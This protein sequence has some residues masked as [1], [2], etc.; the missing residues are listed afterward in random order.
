[1]PPRPRPHWLAAL[2]VLT[3]VASGCAGARYS[4]ADPGAERRAL[5]TVDITT[6]DDGKRASELADFARSHNDPEGAATWAAI[7]QR[8][9]L[10]GATVSDDAKAK[11]RWR[12]ASRR[13]RRLADRGFQHTQHIDAILLSPKPELHRA[14]LRAAVRHADLPADDAAELLE[15]ASR[16]AD[17]AAVLRAWTPWSTARKTHWLEAFDALPSRLRRDPAVLARALDCALD[18]E[19]PSAELAARAT[20]LLEYDPWHVPA[21]LAL[22]INIGNTD[23]DHALWPDIV[24]V[25]RSR[26]SSTVAR[27]QQRYGAE[28]TQARGLALA[29]VLLQSNM[30]G[31]ARVV[32]DGVPAS[33]D[34][35]GEAELVRALAALLA[36]EAAAYDRWRKEHDEP[37][38]WLDERIA[39]WDFQEHG[40]QTR[41]V[42]AAARRRAQRAG[43]PLV[44]TAIRNLL[45]AESSLTQRRRARR[46]LAVTP[47]IARVAE[48]CA[49]VGHSADRCLEVVWG[50]ASAE[51]EEEDLALRLRADAIADYEVADLDDE[52][53]ARLA[54]GAQVAKPGL[55]EALVLRAIEDRRLDDAARQLARDGVVLPARTLLRLELVLKDA[56]AGY[57]DVALGWLP[58]PFDVSSGD[59][60]L[61]VA[62][63]KKRPTARL[64]EALRRLQEEPAAALTALNELTTE[65]DGRSRILLLCYAAIAS[66]AA[67]D[68]GALDEISRSIA[69]D[70]PDSGAAAVVESLRARQRGNS[71]RAREAAGV[72]AVRAPQSRLALDNL[73]RES[74]EAASVEVEVFHGL[75]RAAPY[76]WELHYSALRAA[77]RDEALPTPADV[78]NARELLDQDDDVDTVAMARL[79]PQLADAAVR[80]EFARMHAAGEGSVARSAAAN[81]LTALDLTPESEGWESSRPALLM[82]ADRADEAVLR[83]DASKHGDGVD[84]FSTMAYV[85]R[86][87]ASGALSDT[88]AY[89]LWRWLYSP[90][91]DPPEVLTAIADAPWSPAL[92][93]IACVEA[94]TADAV[95]QARSHCRE[96]HRDFPLD[97]GVAVNLGWAASQDTEDLHIENAL[98]AD[99]P[100]TFLEDR[101]QPIDRGSWSIWFANKAKWQD[102]RGETEQAHQT[103]VDAIALGHPVPKGVSTTESDTLGVLLRHGHKRS[104]VVG[105]HWARVGYLAL[106]NGDVQTAHRYTSA[107][108]RAVTDEADKSIQLVVGQRHAVVEFAQRDLRS[109]AASPDEIGEALR[110]AGDGDEAQLAAFVQAHPDCTLGLAARATRQLDKG[111]AQLAKT[112][113]DALRKLGSHEAATEHLA[114]RLALLEGELPR[115]KAIYARAIRATPGHLMLTAATLPESLR[116][117]DPDVPWWVR[118][119]RSADAHVVPMP[120]AVARRINIASAEDFFAPESWTV[121]AKA[122]GSTTVSGPQGAVVEI[123]ERSRAARC[124]AR[125][126]AAGMLRDWRASG[127]T[128]HWVASTELPAG[129]ATEFVLT[130]NDQV[131]WVSVLAQGGRVFEIEGRA[132]YINADQMLAATRLA[133]RTFRPLDSVLPAFRAESVRKDGAKLS[134]ETRLQIRLAM[135]DTTSACPLDDVLAEL[136][137]GERG[138]ALVDAW[139]SSRSVSQRHALTRCA[140][141][142]QA[143][144]ARLG[145]V[146]LTDDD[147]ALHSFGRRAVAANPVAARRA[148]RAVFIGP[149][150]PALSNADYYVKRDLPPPG[151]LELGRALPAGDRRELVADLLGD[152]DP[153]DR[154]L[155]WTLAMLS[156]NALTFEEGLDAV[157]GQ[158]ALRA[159]RFVLRG[160]LSDAVLDRIRERLLE[161]EPSSDQSRGKAAR[162][163]SIVL[164][165]MSRPTDST[166]LATLAER[167]QG[168]DVGEAIERAARL[169]R[170]VLD[171]TTPKL[172]ADRRVVQRRRDY[173]IQPDRAGQPWRSPADVA[174]R[175]LAALLPGRNWNYV[176]AANPRLTATAAKSLLARVDSDDP[177]SRRIIKSTIDR[178]MEQSGGSL[179]VEG[180]GLDLGR[181]IECA[182]NPSVA[183][184][185]VCVAYIQDHVSL[186]TALTQRNSGDDS[187]PVLPLNLANELVQ[188][189]VK[190]SAAQVRLHAFVAG[191]RRR[192]PS[193]VILRERSRDEVVFGPH[194]LERQVLVE[195]RAQSLAIDNEFYLVAGDRLFV[196]T[197]RNLIDQVL[198]TTESTLADDPRFAELIGAAHASAGLVS[199]ALGRTA[200]AGIEG[201]HE[202]VVDKRGIGLRYTGALQQPVSEVGVLVAA[203]PD[204]A[205]TSV[206]VGAGIERPNVPLAKRADPK[207]VGPAPPPEALRSADGGLAFGWYPVPGKALWKHWVAVLKPTI[208]GQTKLAE[209]KLW[210]HEEDRAVRVE[211]V[212][213][214]RVGDMLIA[215]S[216]PGLLNKSR[217]Q[218]R[219]ASGPRAVLASGRFNGSAVA[220]FLNELPRGGELSD[221]FRRFAATALGL[222]RSAE[223]DAHRSDDGKTVTMRGRIDFELRDERDAPEL[224]DAWLASRDISNSVPLPR[225]V[226]RA[227][228]N[229]ALTYVM[230]VPDPRKFIKYAVVRAPRV[231]VTKAAD[232]AVRIRV[233]AQSSQEETLDSAARKRALAPTADYPRDDPR[234]AKILAAVIKDAPD[235]KTRATRIIAWAHQRIE[236]EVT[237][238]RLSGR[239]ILDAGRGDCS[240]Y[241]VLSVTL[242]RAAG[243]PAEERAGLALD[244]DKMVA[245]AWIAYHDGTRWVEADPT[246]GTTSVTAGHLPMSVFEVLSLHGTG[247]LEVT[248]VESETSQK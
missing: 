193:A 86:A 39:S 238:R 36:G 221:P 35:R 58:T 56:R 24:D 148:A 41:R 129:P 152:Q 180:S 68:L 11:R 76:D 10:F 211:S 1:M 7:A 191:S 158:D 141:P 164:G 62:E 8:Q 131:H 159:A 205:A 57:G 160:D 229:G 202:L 13:A 138:S 65:H 194:R 87:R 91:G 173:P 93:A 242:L 107:A 53:L 59:A 167:W 213:L 69:V 51:H 232:G 147:Y 246:A 207:V 182:E 192:T 145:V 12:R 200:P 28:P 18:L 223:Y 241:A 31:D 134:D 90:D 190:L 95:E 15:F 161:V 30:V 77:L 27:L 72:A 50:T 99:S 195:A 184:G 125:E 34:D 42:A 204:G 117:K 29:L 111:N 231:R 101:L 212:H 45:D 80:V 187:G 67:E 234:V 228:T 128:V 47:G 146:A 115:A 112:S 248:G 126:C 225:L 168:Y 214:I 220:E 104:G 108:V 116:G 203:L 70:A 157:S 218:L 54:N 183:T 66:I 174:S 155:G 100:P 166:A 136:D 32:A 227:E 110:V 114:I 176:R 21:R 96:A 139:L 135:A 178:V 217:D 149:L 61:A 88:Q 165:N 156:D 81:A 154:A 144:A 123:R 163:L 210:P 222:V 124:E 89:E 196:F 79:H 142:D 97:S 38:K 181:K 60:Y 23:D 122:N 206:A 188:L 215:S 83:L 120:T 177:A 63:D 37:S 230:R 209:A 3:L 82:L 9:A 73:W 151:L 245:H 186:L 127:A 224:V 172:A 48:L 103:W 92:T 236:Y 52:G 6:S 150:D 235:L 44:S 49:Q 175:S 113:I 153:R 85:V 106:L 208:A 133:A 226:G 198:R 17:R 46:R 74:E 239:A 216:D 197:S 19:R 43:A 233:A 33:S 237:P 171:G 2:A 102:R 143:V 199:V 20:A 25:A 219:T 244:G 201:I 5:G 118:T 98:Y 14:A 132:S 169:H 105:R 71:D 189:P 140:A 179:F 84:P 119:K 26:D 75:A 94:A 121:E 55:V 137:D 185:A 130:R 64:T 240:E 40:P 243:I 162:L 4:T 16:P 78:I 109:G 22:R 170:H 247:D